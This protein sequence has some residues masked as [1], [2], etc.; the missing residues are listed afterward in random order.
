MD[1]ASLLGIAGVV[2][3]VLVSVFAGTGGDIRAFVNVPAVVLVVGG[4]LAATISSFAFVGLGAVRGMLR[5]AFTED[6]ESLTHTIDEV[7]ELADIARR[8]GLLAVERHLA[9]DDD[10]FLARAVRMVIDGQEPGAIQAALADELE[11]TDARHTANRQ[12]LELLAR[13]CPAF[14]MIGTLVGLVVMLRGMDEPSR[15]GP[16][17]AV[18]LLTT[19]YGLL[20][21]HGVFWPLCHKLAR[22]S[23]DELLR[24]TLV[25]KGVMA[26]QAGENP[27]VVEQR[28]RAFLPARVALARS[29]RASALGDA[30]P[31][32]PN[33]T[34][35]AT[36][37]QVR[38]PL[39]LGK[40]A[41]A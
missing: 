16:G 17:M 22:R 26:I 2:L 14:G 40:S 6:D 25:F 7:L 34:G 29:Q 30:A 41:A 21:A 15:I 36:S 3:L 1:Y 20:L 19:L 23:A 37:S 9:P 11:A 27:S 32:A 13:H 18:A 4:A 12:F 28:L 10:R 33:A 35:S 39:R 5:R 24:K 38:M 8:D 31:S